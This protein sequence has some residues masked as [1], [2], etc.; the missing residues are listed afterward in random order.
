MNKPIFPENVSSY[1]VVFLVCFSCVLSGCSGTFWG[2]SDSPE[3]S[4]A[5]VEGKSDLNEA[6]VVQQEHEETKQKEEP[7]RGAVLKVMPPDMQSE[8]EKS[9]IQ[10]IN[11]YLDLGRNK[12]A[13]ALAD[14]LVRDTPNDYQSYLL[15]ARIKS[16]LG[17]YEDALRDN[18]RAKTVFTANQKKYSKKQRNFRLAKIDENRAV[19]L[20]FWGPLLSSQTKQEAV[21]RQFNLTVER[22]KSR[23][24]NVYRH[25]LGIL[26][27]REKGSQEGEGGDDAELPSP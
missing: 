26:N 19:T 5:P 21:A 4:G 22:I 17:D 10:K 9:R 12:A 24:K 13:L 25:L 18:D 6:P 20:Y 15:R 23:D 11:A 3:G 16:L 7:Q 2:F 27:A 1:L 14:E 8:S